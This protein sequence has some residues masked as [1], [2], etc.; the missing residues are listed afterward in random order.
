MIN[1]VFKVDNILTVND[2]LDQN[3]IN[4]IRFTLRVHL[5]D[6]E[7]NLNDNVESRKRDEI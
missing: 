4:S 7:T 1:C 2:I 5:R 6:S 3:I